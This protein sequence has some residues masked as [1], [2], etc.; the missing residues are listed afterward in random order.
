MAFPPHPPLRLQTELHHP[1]GQQWSQGPQNNQRRPK[2]KGR[3]QVKRATHLL[4]LTHGEGRKKAQNT[5]KAQSLTLA[6]TS[7]PSFSQSLKLTEG[8]RR[9]NGPEASSRARTKAQVSQLTLTVGLR[10]MRGLAQT[11]WNI[12]SPWGQQRGTP[13]YP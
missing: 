8:I 10:L 3:T 7:F 6:E 11:F 5:P 13:Y 4:K 12:L 2:V 1:K 9:Y